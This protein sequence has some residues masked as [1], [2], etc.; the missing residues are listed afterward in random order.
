MRK[1]H[2]K[3][4]RL[5]ELL[6]AVQRNVERIEKREIVIIQKYRVK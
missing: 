6:A 5:I 3:S 1:K 4:A 2:R